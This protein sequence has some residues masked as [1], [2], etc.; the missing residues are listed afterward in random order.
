MRALDIEVIV[1]RM[2][3][4]KDMLMKTGVSVMNTGK[5]I[6]PAI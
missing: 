2:I 6:F 4:N 1:S 5:N 3:H